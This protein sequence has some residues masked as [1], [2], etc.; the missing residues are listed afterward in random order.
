MTNDS[1]GR[2]ANAH[3]AHTDLYGFKTEVCSTVL[4]YYYRPYSDGHSFIQLH[5]KIFHFSDKFK[6]LN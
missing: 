3:L 5:L 6:S 1:I 2:I 4:K